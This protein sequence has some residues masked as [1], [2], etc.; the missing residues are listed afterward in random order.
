MIASQ[1][2]SLPGSRARRPALLASLVVLALACV[3]CETTRNLVPAQP[4]TVTLTSGPIDTTSAPQS[5]LVDI[6]WTATDPDGRIDHS[7]Y[8]I[9][10]PSLKQAR[11]AA[12]ETTWVST[13]D[14]HVVARFHASH[15]DSLGARGA[16]ASEFHVFVLRAVDDRGGVSPRV[17]RGFYAT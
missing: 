8:A 5:W 15:P 3:A 17:V 13:H 14:S 12:A 10:P 9:D 7:E 16:T 6:A 11:L 4:P 1:H 2:S